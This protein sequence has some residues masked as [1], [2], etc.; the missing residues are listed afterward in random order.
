[1]SEQENNNKK[2]KSLE[3][4]DDEEQGP[5]ERKKPRMAETPAVA[6]PPVPAYRVV[7][8]LDASKQWWQ[9]CLLVQ[10]EEGELFG[11]FFFLDFQS[12]PDTKT[13]DRLHAYVQTHPD[14]Y[15]ALRDEEYPCSSDFKQRMTGT[16][17]IPK[18]PSSF[19]AIPGQPLQITRSVFLIS[20]ENVLEEG[21]DEED[22]DDEASM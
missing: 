8:T 18:F 19:Q 4:D 13:R 22:D 17:Y 14:V 10:S 5:S 1:M 9:Y 21:E 12:I 3:R 2:R 6:N 15:Y 20:R 7:R 16:W 11:H